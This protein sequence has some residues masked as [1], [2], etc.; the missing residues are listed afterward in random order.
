[1]SGN[2]SAGSDPLRRFILSHKIALWI[3]AGIM[4][5]VVLSLSR[6]D[7]DGILRF[8]D[9]LQALPTLQ[10][11]YAQLSAKISNATHDVLLQTYDNNDLYLMRELYAGCI[12]GG[13]SRL[14]GSSRSFDEVVAD[15]GR[16]LSP[17]GW[18]YSTFGV[19]DRPGY[20]T[21]STKVVLNPI[22]SSAPDYPAVKEKYQTVYKLS[23]Q[24]D[25]PAIELCQ[26]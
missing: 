6:I 4:V 12:R 10:A 8:S 7:I 3:I 25:D 11:D 22:S 16:V 9:R 14:Y 2:Y 1:M 23:F 17:I 5:I 15:Y 26:G 13:F 21:K 20:Y 24:Y 18:Q 19:W